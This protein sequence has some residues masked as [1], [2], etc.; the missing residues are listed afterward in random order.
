MLDQ[1]TLIF[2]A[3]GED[4]FGSWLWSLDV[5]RTGAAPRRIPTGLDQYTS[6]SASRDRGPLVATRANPTATLWSVPILADRQAVESD[7]VPLR[8]DTERALAPRYA[9]RA[10][11]PLLFYL[12]ARGTGD[13]AWGFQTTSFEITRGRKG[14]C[15]SRRRRR[16]T[17]AGW[18]S[19]S[20]RRDAGIFPS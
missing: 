17:G 13:R 2:V 11:A 5:G 3:P 7:V 18:R 20:R 8:L 14:T 10:A 19:S 16:L 6:I 9:R 15:P 4:G 12:S 1:D